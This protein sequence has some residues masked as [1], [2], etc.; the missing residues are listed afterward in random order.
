[1]TAK[2]RPLPFMNL[3][4]GCHDSQ[5]ALFLYLSLAYHVLWHVAVD[6]LIE[7]KRTISCR[8]TTQSRVEIEHNRHLSDWLRLNNRYYISVCSAVIDHI[9][10]IMGK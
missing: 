8:V 10:T 3:W 1:M 2:L 9:H 4:E 6:S 7:E 5:A